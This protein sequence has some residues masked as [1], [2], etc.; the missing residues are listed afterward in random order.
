M[1][2][3]KF[4]K[5]G[6]SGKHN[7]NGGTS[8]SRG[9]AL[10]AALLLVVLLSAISIGLLMMVR[11]EGMAGGYDGQNTMAYHATEGAI[12]KMTTDLAN[13]F[14][15]IQAP[16]VSDITGLSSKV[17]ANTP[18]VQYLAYNFTPTLD[19]A[20]GKIAATYKLIPNGPNAGLFAQTIQVQLQAT[21]QTGLNAQ[22]S[23]IR[24]VEVALIPVFQFGVFSDSDLGFYSSPNLTFNGRV[25]TNQDLYLGVSVGATVTFNDK[26]TAFGNVVRQVL[27]NGLASSSN[28]NTGTVD[29]LSA[30]GGCSA[31]AGPNCK[32]MAITDGSVTGG[33][34]SAQNASWPTVSKS[35]YAGWILD[36]NY[37]GPNGT[38]AV[39]L[40]MPFTNSGPVGGGPAGALPKTFE[41]IR[42]A[43]PADSVALAQARLY[44]QAEIRVLLSDDPAD[45]PGGV[46]DPANIRLANVQTVAGAP[47]YTRGV[48][49]PVPATY[50]SLGLGVTYNSYFAEASTAVPDP[51]RMV[52]GTTKVALPADWPTT[53]AA[54]PAGHATLVPT[55]AVGATP[56]APFITATT[57]NLIDGY[58]RVEYRDVTGAYTPI[59]RE[60]LELGFAR[61]LLPPN[62]A[63]PNTVNPKAILLLQ[64]PA[65]RDGN[66]TLDPFQAHAL[67]CPTCAD[68][69]AD[70]P[71]D[72]VMAALPAQ[73]AGLYG[74]SLLATSLSRNNW[75]PINFYDAREGETRDQDVAGPSCTVAGV[76]NAVELDVANLKRWLLDVTGSGPKVTFTDHNGYILYFSDRRGM[77]PNANQG[78]LKTGDAGFEDVIN[79]ASTTGVPDKA[80]EPVPPATPGHP[81]LSPEDVNQDGNLDNWGAW[82]L[83][84]GFRM[85]TTAP[86]NVYGT[87][88]MPNCF[89]NAGMNGTATAANAT[90]ANPP[91]RKN[92]V[93][94][95]R[96][97]LRLVDGT[98]TGTTAAAAVVAL[99]V[100]PN[101]T[102][103]GFTVASENPVYILGNYNTNASDTSWPTIPTT[104]AGIAAEFPHAD[105]AVIAD[106]VTLL[107]NSWT[108][109]A[110]LKTPTGATTNRPASTTYYR[111]AIAAGKNITF[112][113]PSY[114]TGVL[115]GFGTDGGVHNFLRFLEDWSGQTLNYGGSMVSLFYSTYGTGT[116]KCCNDAVYH[117]P[118]RNYQF[119]TDFQDPNKLPPG[120]PMFRDINNLSFRQDFTPSASKAPTSAY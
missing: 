30:A 23:L 119:D 111:T 40:V 105:S 62:P 7:L 64:K 103:G 94:G 20:T 63:A 25:H 12:E 74:S 83:G 89:N 8:H 104:P 37:G 88:R 97:V 16:Q 81:A 38:G 78:N 109:Y 106:A 98:T 100:K 10:L 112:P 47:D 95:A 101:G 27:P 61:G 93:S 115:Y 96:H 13:A 60:W 59:T 91:G 2:S 71:N 114:A 102:G 41:I 107:S 118:A 76:M 69:P 29:I 55:T 17:P 90:L 51:T 85:N 42:R 73:A 77:H 70:T 52:L 4:R 33:P 86:L 50:P 19:P 32:S 15:T 24:G 39:K 116:F 120:T 11:S 49:V 28:N 113:N 80:L 54:P 5:I 66:G 87:A 82:N 34:A 35:T 44:N 84:A 36:G 67:A 57:W 3:K 18:T 72:L 9:F 22:A 46:A 48:P 53:P 14:T 99:P 65:D 92:W 108:D 58:L 21:T 1:H 43:L 110:S 56:A 45:L 31:G 68:R 79:A 75:Y 6:K 26:I 117:P